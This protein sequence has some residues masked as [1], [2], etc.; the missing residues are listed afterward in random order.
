MDIWRSSPVPQDWVDAILITLYKDKDS[1]GKCGDYR[2]I[3][4]VEAA[5]KGFARLLLN[6]LTN[7]VCPEVIPLVQCGFRSG[8]GIVDMVFTAIQL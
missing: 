2:G 6:R 4:L 1:K 8:R 5:G 3:S 7:L